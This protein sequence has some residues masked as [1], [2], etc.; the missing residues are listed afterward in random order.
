M[1]GRLLTYGFRVLSAEDCEDVDTLLAVHFTGGTCALSSGKSGVKPEG[2]G[3][4]PNSNRSHK[5]LCLSDRWR[6]GHTVELAHQGI[7]PRATQGNTGSCCVRLSYSRFSKH[8]EVA[9]ADV[10]TVG[11]VVRSEGRTVQSHKGERAGHGGE[12][13]KFGFGCRRRPYVTV[14]WRRLGPIDPRVL[15]QRNIDVGQV[16]V[17][18]DAVGG[19]FQNVWQPRSMICIGK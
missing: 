8:C 6:E 5:V 2:G 13:T 7:N 19:C 17:L 4:V 3:T 10:P 9:I 16:G 1:G 12:A 14:S 18:E 11:K 15:R